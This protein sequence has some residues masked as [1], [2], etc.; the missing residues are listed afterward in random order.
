MSGSAFSK[1]VAPVS[2]RMT[3][4]EFRQALSGAIKAGTKRSKYGAK[5]VVNEDG[6]FDSQ[7]E[8]RRF[9]NLRLLE[10]A[11]EI[12]NLRRQVRYP[13]QAGGIHIS[14]YIADFVY[15]QN[16]VEVVEDSKGFITPEYRQKRRLMKEILGIEI[17]ETGIASSAPSPRKK[18]ST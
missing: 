6:K 9:L 11:G 13:L 2:G 5:K 10:R 4:A 18:R 12:Q 16:G 1:V 15:T 8:Y 7:E 3:S 17:L 14:V